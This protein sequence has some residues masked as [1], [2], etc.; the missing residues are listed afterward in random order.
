MPPAP[1]P[2]YF[3]LA[4]S[5]VPS[6]TKPLPHNPKTP[7]PLLRL[8]LRDL[9]LD[10]V[11]TS[12]S[13]IDATCALQQCIETIFRVL[14]SPQCHVPTTRSVTLILR[15]MPGVAYTTGISIDDD[16]KEI[17]LSTDYIHGIAKD[18]KRE[19]IMGVL[20]H[21]MVHCFQFNALGSAPGG[22]IEGIADFVRLKAG[23]SP[24]HWK[25]E[26]G[27]DW[28]AG[29]QHTAYFLEY[30]DKVCGEGTVVRCNEMLRHGKYEENK[31]WKD[32][33]GKTVK[34]L[35]A[36]YNE[37]LDGGKKKG[38]GGNRREEKMKKANLLLAEAVRLQQEAAKLITE[39]Q[40]ERDLVEN[41]DEHGV[42]S[43]QE[44]TAIAGDKQ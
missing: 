33:C 3:Q 15:S 6:T 14:Y 39:A 18:R 29:Y 28:D 27:G 32:C 44:E 10:G 8:E 16:H 23:L 1:T 12:I 43:K 26:G 41:G 11:H 13:C 9:S 20:Q 24:P 40:E 31:F 25:R 5:P 4:M 30:L 36:E 2:T 19:E 38:N 7:K 34:Q 17:H 35:W 22:L 21:E 37:M 42:Q